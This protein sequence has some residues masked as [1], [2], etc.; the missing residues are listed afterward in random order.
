M[1]N[2]A[3]N[4]TAMLAAGVFIAVAPAMYAQE[5]NP[6]TMKQDQADLAKERGIRTQDDRTLRD[7]SD[8]IRKLEAER[9]AVSTQ[10]IADERAWSAAQAKLA[11]DQKSHASSETIE[12][13]RKA[14]EQALATKERDIQRRLEF[15]QKIA[16]LKAQF[17]SN[18][19]QR[20]KDTAELKTEEMETRRDRAND[21]TEQNQDNR[22]LTELN[23]QIRKLEA[24]RNALN[25]EINN[26]KNA[27]NSAEAKLAA[28]QK[29]H[30]SSAQL[31]QDRLALRR[32]D[33]ARRKDMQHAQELDQKIA[34]L[35]AQYAAEAKQ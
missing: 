2:K 23:M 24:E 4:K 13:D 22:N 8:Q 34:Q 25:T 3:I 21:R 30:A 6:D 11:A 14:V 19:S 7:L 20:N 29:N 10:T 17:A 18:N 16:Q 5:P 31:E 35:K 12:Q 28:D 32:A 33:D 27:A 26:D 1:S 15:D 9:G